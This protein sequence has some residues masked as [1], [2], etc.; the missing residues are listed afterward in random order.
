[1]KLLKALTIFFVYLATPAGS[2]ERSNPSTLFG[3]RSI[4]SER[5]FNDMVFCTVLIMKMEAN[6]GEKQP[7]ISKRWFDTTVFLADLE[8]NDPYLTMIMSGKFE[9][10]ITSE[11]IYGQEE[12]ASSYDDLCSMYQLTVNSLLDIVKRS[13]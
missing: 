11:E 4:I 3:P 2:E 10:V 12:L 1:M 7:I 6:V 8:K 13:Q 5:Q 9:E